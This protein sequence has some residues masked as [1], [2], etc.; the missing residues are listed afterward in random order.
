MWYFKLLQLKNIIFKI[1]MI[2]KHDILNK[3]L[4]EPEKIT[5]YVEE[6]KK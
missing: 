2:E 6:V 4:N 1:F 5:I 3:L